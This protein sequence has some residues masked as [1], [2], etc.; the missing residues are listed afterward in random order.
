MYS[1]SSISLTPET[2]GGLSGLSILSSPIVQISARSARTRSTVA[3]CEEWR[4]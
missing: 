4:V 2:D 1:R 3:G